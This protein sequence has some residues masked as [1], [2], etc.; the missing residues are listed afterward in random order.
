MAG[1]VVRLLS[2][3]VGLPRDHG[4]EGAEEPMDR[5][6]T[7]GF[8][9]EPVSG[10]IRVGRTNLEGDG[11]ADLVN[12]GGWDK[13]VLAYSA[14]HYPGWRAELER[15]DLPFGAFGENLTVSGQ[16]EADVCIGDTFAIGQARL[17]VT[18]PRQPCWKLARRWRVKDLPARVIATGRSGW[19]LRV[20]EEAEIEAGLPIE[21]LERP[22]PEW[23]AL[24]AAEIMYDRRHRVQEAHALAACPLLSAAWREV[25]G[26]A[27]TE[28]REQDN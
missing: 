20:L 17:Q 26:K 16:S 21:L 2:I 6:W 24:H 18:Q 12:H 27:G 25:L 13:A 28:S 14:D 7:S 1:A 5:L 3:Q 9:K 23:T 8:F 4:V 15:H 22:Y 10:A 11:Q 19:Y